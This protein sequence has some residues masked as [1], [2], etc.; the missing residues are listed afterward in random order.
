[1][2]MI[3]WT[4]LLL[5]DS[6][7]IPHGHCYLW[8]I[9]L[10]SL[11]VV[12][13]ALI[14][15]ACYGISVFII[16]FTFRIEKSSVKNISILFSAFILYCG[17][18]HLGEIWTIWHPN[19]WLFGI[20]KAATAL[21]AIYTALSLI[22]LISQV[23]ELPSPQQLADL[24]RKL[25]EQITDTEAAKQEIAQ[26]NQKLEQRVDEK[27]AA[28]IQTN[29]DLQ[30]SNKFREKL[31]DLTPN[32]LYIFD[33]K[34]SRNVYCN[35]FITDLL[36]YTPF[37]LQKFKDGVID[38]LIHPED[39]PLLKRH[40]NN[41]L[42]LKEDN[43]LEIEYRIRDTNGEWHWLHDKNT[44]FA[45]DAKGK[46]EQI[47]G[48][49]QDITQTKELNQKLEEQIWVLEKTNQSRIKLARMNEFI[50]A[51]LSL[52][53]AKEIIADL[54]QPLFANT[55]GV[56]YLINNSKNLFEAIAHWGIDSDSSFE[57]K[58]CWAIR[59]GNPHV[60]SPQNPKLYCSHAEYANTEVQLNHS[61][62][63]PMIAKGET[64][65][66]LHLRFDDLEIGRESKNLAETV[67]QNLAMSFAN[68]KLQEELR[69]QSL[70]DPLTSLYNR[71]YL[72]ETL[73]KEIDRASRK[74]QFLSLMMLDV[75]HFKRF[76]DVY[77]HSAGDLVLNQV[78]AYLLS[79]IRQYDVACRYGGEELVIL[80]PD[81]SIDNTIVRAESIRTGIKKLQLK[82]EG[83]QLEP[84][85]VSIGVSCFPDD[86]TNPEG[87]IRAADK[88]LYQ[89]KEQ[90]RDCVIRC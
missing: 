73:V 5:L 2:N 10:I 72:Q 39:I 43:Y 49:A 65:G 71:R 45:R 82:H 54:L 87:L 14:T 70:R 53:E 34:Q 16:Y 7:Y 36:G 42:F 76:N 23:F 15:I 24:N 79:Q 32:L 59:R 28:L 74:Q 61:L 26:L 60:S 6:P 41:C 67:A 12:S 77:G 50:Q 31:T 46:P 21:I 44:I 19:Y 51:C 57:P 64:I 38:E 75:D 62:C 81:A 25:S 48:I 66:M 90:G 40:F 89:A 83:K 47:L 35:P 27:T 37:E 58:D 17:T 85:S 29:Q 55:K 52:T 11:H 4:Q 3:I 33:L 63:L 20:L 88:A 22:P 68:L 30:D 69:Y 1:M 8:Q 80:M 9:P 86:S 18:T 13:D 78:G 56:V 84:I